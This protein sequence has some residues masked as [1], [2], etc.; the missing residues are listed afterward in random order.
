MANPRCEHCRATMPVLIRRHARFCSVRCR[1][2]A[3]RARPRIPLELR[4]R[5]LW[6]RRSVRKVP[7]TAAGEAASSTNPATWCDYETA[8]TS[9]T[10]VGS[11]FVLAGDGIVCIDL[12][13]CLDDEGAP[14]GWVAPILAAC[15]GTWIEVSPSGRGLHVWGLAA[16]RGGRRRPYRGHH[17][18]VYGSGRY[19]AVTGEAFR[20]APARLSDLSAV[21]AEVL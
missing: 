11:G 14:A 8:R 4:E 13:D 16:F 7:L 20:Q 12:D 19:I 2:S 10:G 9:K 6:V 17:V 3:H 1:V 18:E 15:P 21:L 5:N